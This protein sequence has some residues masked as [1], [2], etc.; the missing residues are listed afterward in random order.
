M[1]VARTKGGSLACCHGFAVAAGDE[2]VGQVETPVFTGTDVEPESLLL[3]TVEGIP[4]EFA[5]VPVT[6]VTTVDEAEQL[7]TLRGTRDELFGVVPPA[8]PLSTGP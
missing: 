6:E 1:S 2:P 8:R 4:G 5:A 7:I 3:R